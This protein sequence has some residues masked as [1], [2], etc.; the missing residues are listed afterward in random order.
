M[1]R[2]PTHL[3]HTEE[4]PLPIYRLPRPS[5]PPRS[6]RRLW[7]RASQPPP[8]SPRCTPRPVG[9]SRSKVKMFLRRFSRPMT[10]KATLPLPSSLTA[11][12]YCTNSR[13]SRPGALTT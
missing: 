8:L 10:S 3:L 4:Q 6:H 1:C 13:T 2:H 7:C 9:E 12:R 5:P 11:I